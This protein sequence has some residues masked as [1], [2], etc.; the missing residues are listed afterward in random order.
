MKKHFVYSA[1]ALFS[2]PLVVVLCGCTIK[3]DQDASILVVDV[4]PE[5]AAERLK[6]ESIVVLDVRTPEE[7]AMGRIPGSVNVNITGPDF[8]AGIAKLGP[9]KT[10][11]VHCARGVPGGRSRQSIE[12]LESLGVKKVY[13]LEGGFVGWQVAE[14][15]VEVPAPQ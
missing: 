10:Y 7:V 4:Q 8:A 3:D 13:H 12:A 15:R 11:M 1:M 9:A 14:N 6:N 5:E 2:L